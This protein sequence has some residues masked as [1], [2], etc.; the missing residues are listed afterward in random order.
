ML[1]QLFVT[2]GSEA[3]L[4]TGALIFHVIC[5]TLL[6]PGMYGW[7]KYWTT[8]DRALIGLLLFVALLPVIFKRYFLSSYSTFE[9]LLIV[10]FLIAL[11]QQ[12]R[13]GI[14]VGLMLLAALTRET[15][16]VLAFVYLAWNWDKI[17]LFFS[18]KRDKIKK[19]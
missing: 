8:E 14:L 7:L 10:Y 11:A 17:R 16:I 19:D 13:F 15:G 6:Y 4:I 1:V 18:L 2:N 9:L 3:A 12:A 5:F